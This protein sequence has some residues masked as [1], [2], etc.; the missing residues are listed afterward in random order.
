MGASAA[1]NKPLT[2]VVLDQLVLAS[3]RGE[4]LSNLPRH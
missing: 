3:P 1:F 4:S 2:P